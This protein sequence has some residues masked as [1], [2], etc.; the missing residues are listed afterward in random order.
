L[1]KEQMSRIFFARKERK[2]ALIPHAY[3]FRQVRPLTKQETPNHVTEAHYILAI[4]PLK[5]SARITKFQGD[6][7]KALKHGI[8]R[9]FVGSLNPHKDQGAPGGSG[10]DS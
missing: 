7:P 10:T 4:V 9:Y 5:F 6:V 8:T 1:K 3:P 2:R